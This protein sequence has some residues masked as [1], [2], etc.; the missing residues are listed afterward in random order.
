[1]NILYNE[2]LKKIRFPF[3]LDNDETGVIVFTDA[4]S[5]I[6][7]AYLLASL[8]VPSD[9][10]KEQGLVWQ[11]MWQNKSI[12]ITNKESDSKFYFPK[13]QHFIIAFFEILNSTVCAN[14]YHFN[15][16]GQQSTSM[17][18]SLQHP[19]PMLL[20]ELQIGVGLTATQIAKISAYVRYIAI[21]KA[22][23]CFY[24]KER[25]AAKIN[26]FCR[27]FKDNRYLG[28]SSAFEITYLQDMWLEILNM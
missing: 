11:L 14:E 3:E 18:S 24:P 25:Y 10:N 5:D 12:T 4:H 16:N 28:V 23:P 1:M 8:G 22:F 26:G 15:I 27:D 19:K 20:N 13:E 9:Y 21:A 2:L 6:I 7:N 17:K